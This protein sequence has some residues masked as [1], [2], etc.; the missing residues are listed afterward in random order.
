MRCRH[1]WQLQHDGFGPQIQPG[2]GIG[3]VVVGGDDVRVGRSSGAAVVTEPVEAAHIARKGLVLGLVPEGLVA[4]QG[5]IGVEP[6]L[7]GDGLRFGG[8]GGLAPQRRLGLVPVRRWPLPSGRG[9]I[10]G[11]RPDAG[12]WSS[13]LDRGDVVELPGLGEIGLGGAVEAEVGESALAR[14][15][16]DPVLG[17]S[18]S[19]GPEIHINRAV[20]V[21]HQI[22]LAGAEVGGAQGGD[23]WAAAEVV[24]E[25]DRPELLHRRIGRHAQAIPV[26]AV[27]PLALGVLRCLQ[28]HLAEAHYPAL[29]PHRH[30]DRFVE[31]G[32]ALVEL[33]PQL[34]GRFLIQIEQHRV[35][36]V[37]AGY[38]VAPGVRLSMAIVRAIRS[39]SWAASPRIRASR[40]SGLKAWPGAMPSGESIPNI[41]RSRGATGSLA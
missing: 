29:H 24:V 10:L 33:H 3:R 15:G 28:I 30:G 4:L 40:A 37:L 35:L 9:S 7:R 22:G 17:T 25:G 19:D 18:R 27:E 12:G 11:F 32:A 34:V 26:A 13:W 8:G 39:P 14:R 31:P 16:L 21:A 36:P 41:I 1:G 5:G 20:G 23:Q 2:P 38:T 6:G